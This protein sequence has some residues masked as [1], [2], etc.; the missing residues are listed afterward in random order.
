MPTRRNEFSRKWRTFVE[1]CSV[2]ESIDAWRVFAQ[3]CLDDG[4]TDNKETAFLERMRFQVMGNLLLTVRNL[5]ISYEM[6]SPSKL[7]HP[8]SFG[9]TLHYL[10][11]T[12]RLSQQ[13]FHSTVVRLH[14]AVSKSH[15]VNQ[16]NQVE[17]TSG[18]QSEFDEPL[19]PSF[20]GHVIS[21]QRDEVFVHLLDHQMSI[22]NWNG[23]P[24]SS[25]QRLS[26][27]SL[28]K[29]VSRCSCLFQNDL[30]L[31][32]ATSDYTPEFDE[33]KY[34]AYSRLAPHPRGSNTGA[35]CR[36]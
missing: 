15:Q 6:K 7:G 21:G 1:L 25:G 30:K 31:K 9:I 4:K 33:M 13:P 23:L 14:T 28:E 22:Q 35:L 12:V 8:F 11:L 3:L 32:I 27:R 34:S 2:S 5:H 20:D 16:T 29:R 24:R 10:E 18:L 19:S 17:Q 26:D 36:L